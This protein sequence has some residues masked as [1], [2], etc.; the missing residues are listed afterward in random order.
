MKTLIKVVVF[1]PRQNVDNVSLELATL[2]WAPLPLLYNWCGWVRLPE[3]LQSSFSKNSISKASV[4]FMF[5]L[6]TK[7]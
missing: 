7:D 2:C 5:C 6:N 4:G 1:C 3:E